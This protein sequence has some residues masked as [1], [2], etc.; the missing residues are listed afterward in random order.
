MHKAPPFQQI[1]L[2]NGLL[3]GI[4]CIIITLTLLS[5]DINLVLSLWVWLGYALIIGVKVYTAISLRNA[6]NNT[7]EFKDG[8]RALFPISVVALFMW[9]AF[10]GI[11]FTKIAPELITLSKEKTI[12]R[13]IW[14]LE[15]SGADEHTIKS[16]VEEAESLDYTPSFK[17]SAIN[18]AQSCIVGFLYSLIIAGFFHYISDFKPRSTEA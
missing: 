8:I 11:L 4:G 3:T 16:A 1:G 12:E 10:N 6:N 13:S 15:K 18:Y 5:L 7:L 17:N 14:V 9:I 2:K